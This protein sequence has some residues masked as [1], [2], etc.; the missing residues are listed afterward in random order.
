MHVRTLLITGLVAGSALFALGGA[1]AAPNL[2]G[3]QASVAPPLVQQV[4]WGGRCE[5]VRRRCARSYEWGTWRFRR[6]VRDR[7]C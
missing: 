3:P 7:G 1:N 6:C 2:A 4:Q 5:S